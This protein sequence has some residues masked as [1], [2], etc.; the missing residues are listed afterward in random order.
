V[1]RHLALLSGALLATAA[2][3]AGCSS[4][5]T[6][7]PTPDNSTESSRASSTSITPGSIPK[8][9]RPANVTKVEVV[10]LPAKAQV[11]QWGT[12]ISQDEQDCI[13]YVIYKAVEDDPTIAS[14]DYLLA[15]VTGGSL[16]ACVPQENLAALLT[17]DLKGKA[18]D[19]QIACVKQEIVAADPQSLAVFLGGLVIQL[20][21][22]VASVSQA[23]DA[24]C[25]TSLATTT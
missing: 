17:E 9:T 13:N 16:V 3:T 12:A 23:L 24:T 21:S 5:D 22:I 6:G 20:P 19:T 18:T 2:L 8:V 4:T 25:G 14:N 1:R 7:S 11:A 15:G 10:Q